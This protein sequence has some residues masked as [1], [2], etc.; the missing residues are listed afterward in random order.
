MMKHTMLLLAGISLA[1]VSDYDFMLV[2]STRSNT[3]AGRSYECN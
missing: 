3:Y 2:V 1:G